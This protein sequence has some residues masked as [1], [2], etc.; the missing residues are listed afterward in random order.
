MAAGMLKTTILIKPNGS[1]VER[2]RNFN[3]D[4]RLSTRL[5]ADELRLSQST[6]WWIATENLVMRKV[7]AKLVSKVLSVDQ[8]KWSMTVCQE[9]LKRLNVDPNFLEKV[10]IG[11][12]TWVYE[13]DPES[14]RRSSEWHTASSPKPKKARMS[15]SRVHVDCYFM[16]KE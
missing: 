1:N 10:V 8:K 16:V 14:K 6:V 11:D 7:C 9:M 13:Y 3:N 15:K 12:E 4:H 2:V 5:I